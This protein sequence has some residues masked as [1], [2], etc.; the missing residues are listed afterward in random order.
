MPKESIFSYRGGDWKKGPI[1]ETLESFGMKREIATIVGS[2]SAAL[3]LVK[4]SDLV[5]TVPERYT[6]NL[7]SGMHTFPLPFPEP[8]IT[9][10][11]IWHPR[12]D[13]DPAHRWLRECVRE[14]CTDPQA[15][16]GKG[17]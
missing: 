9:M 3:A 17:S 4:T 12:M 1:D 13:A 10:S 11:I 14:I 8:A 7:R 6:G 5:A 2:F 15:L 16:P